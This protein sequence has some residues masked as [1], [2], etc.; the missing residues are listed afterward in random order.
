MRNVGKS[1]IIQKKKSFQT[2]SGMSYPHCKKDQ[3]L[4]QQMVF[5]VKIKIYLISAFLL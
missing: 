4:Y 2:V 3:M 5:S 1:L